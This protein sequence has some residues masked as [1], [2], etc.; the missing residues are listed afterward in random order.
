V[1]SSQSDTSVETLQRTVR[2]LELK[3][4]SVQGE[5]SAT[6]AALT[7]TRQEYENYKVTMTTSWE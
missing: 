3:M 7:E 2:T 1:L 6:Q 5:L 4:G